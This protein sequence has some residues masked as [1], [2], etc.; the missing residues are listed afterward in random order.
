M[1][2]LVH[3]D[4]KRSINTGNKLTR[5]QFMGNMALATAGVILLPSFKS[6]KWQIG[7]YTRPWGK[8]DYRVAFDGIAGA[9]FKFVG[10]MSGNVITY[11]TTTEQAAIVGEEAKARGLK[12]ASV[13]GGNFD[14]K[15]SIQ[16]GITGMKSLIDN[17]VSCGSPHLLLTGMATPEL[18]DNYYKV[19]AECCDYASEKGVGISVKPHGP[20][21]STGRECRPLISKVNNKNF[22]LWYDPGNIFYYSDGKID[23]VD[24]AA[25]VD[26][27]V[28]GLIIKDFRMPKDVNVTPGTGMVDFPKVMARLSKGG[29][30]KGPLIVECLNSGELDYINGEAKKAFLFLE[31]LTK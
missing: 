12:I 1:K 16:D 2:N 14:V 9:G 13:Y 23:P 21:N 29:F 26:G 4:V 31:Q 20:L 22:R 3:P 19:V 15:K 11:K 30:K 27:I 28:S 24:D 7:C 18:V 17:A 8:Y 5:R 25:E 10:M 6:S